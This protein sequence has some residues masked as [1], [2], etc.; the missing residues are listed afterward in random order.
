MIV[1]VCNALSE[2]D[3]HQKVAEG[4]RNFDALRS[5]T[6]CSDCCGCCET[7]ARRV[8]ADAQAAQHRPFALPLAAVAA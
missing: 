8:F 4:L 3:I 6:G 7:A 2:S 1:C 5:E